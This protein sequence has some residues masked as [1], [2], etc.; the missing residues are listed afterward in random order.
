MMT[1]GLTQSSDSIVPHGGLGLQNNGE[2]N[3]EPR[4]LNISQDEDYTP[5]EPSLLADHHLLLPKLGVPPMPSIQKNCPWGS[6]AS[7]S[8]QIKQPLKD[9]ESWQGRTFF[10]F[11]QDSQ[12]LEKDTTERGLIIINGLCNKLIK[13]KRT[14]RN[15][16]TA[17]IWVKEN[18]KRKIPA[19][20]PN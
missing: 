19:T 15:E 20:S 4:K 12:F 9:K 17:L 3:Y 11:Y 18:G 5:I 10:R 13:S 16:K 14:R 2:A 7:W 6:I 8:F 1:Q